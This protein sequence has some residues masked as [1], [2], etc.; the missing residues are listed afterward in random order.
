MTTQKE[1]LLLPIKRDY[2]SRMFTMIFS[3]KEELLELYNA[4]SGKHYTTDN[5]RVHTRGDIEGISGA[6]Q[7][8]GDGYEY[9]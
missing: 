5:H 3:K 2:K 1:E 7:S 6:E 4:V 9:L 8:G